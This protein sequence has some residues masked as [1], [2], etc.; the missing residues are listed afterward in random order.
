MEQHKHISKQTKECKECNKLY[1]SERR[2]KERAKKEVL[3]KAGAVKLKTHKLFEEDKKNIIELYMSGISSEEIAKKFNMSGEGI[4]YILK[5]NG[6]KLRANSE[7]HRVL[8]LNEERFNDLTDEE[9]LYWL[10]FLTADG[11]INNNAINLRLTR[12]DKQHLEKFKEFMSSGA[13]VKEYIVNAFEKEYK[14]CGI[15]ITSQKLVERLMELGFTKERK[16][17]FPEWVEGLSGGTFRHWLRGIWDGDGSV[18]IYNAHHGKNK[19]LVLSLCGY[20]E[21]LEPIRRKLVEILGI[22]NN[23]LIK[24]GKIVSVEWWGEEAELLYHYLYDNAKVYLE[25]KKTITSFK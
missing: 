18:G 16:N 3:I 20:E 17:V 8:K 12:K 14:A 2:K 25:R 22:K 6:V 19:Y 4:C 13:E 24:R 15:N 11:S 5:K 23:K 9:E 7:S 10:G 21:L 1:Y